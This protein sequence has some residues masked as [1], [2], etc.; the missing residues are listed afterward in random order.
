MRVT[1]LVGE[2]NPFQ[3]CTFFSHS[4]ATSLKKLGWSVDLVF[5]SEKTGFAE[6]Q[7]IFKNPPDFTLSFS[8]IHVDHCSLGTLWSIPHISLLLDPVFYSLHHCFPENCYVTVV[9]ETEVIFLEKQNRKT[10]FLPH[11]VDKNFA[12]EP[13]AEKN[14]ELLFFGTLIDPEEFKKRWKE[15]FPSEQYQQL[16]ALSDSYALSSSS[17]LDFLQEQ[18]VP[19]DLWPKYHFEID[20]YTRMKERAELLYECR[21]LSLSIWGKGPFEKFCPKAKIAPPCSFADAMQLMKQAKALLNSSIRFKNGAHERIFFAMGARCISITGSYPYIT[22]RYQ[23]G[24]E[25]IGFH[26]QKLHGLSDRIQEILRSKEKRE[27]ITQKAWEKVIQ[28]DTFDER[29]KDLKLFCEYVKQ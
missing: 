5:L 21:N 20:H 3:C 12:L 25:F 18:E 16:I 19:H 4:L 1:F 26:P 27:E 11:A 23:E 24:E 14:M 7:K 2:N 29:A 17:F 8:D 6:L 15:I 10:I 22:K 28:K 9:D 13:I